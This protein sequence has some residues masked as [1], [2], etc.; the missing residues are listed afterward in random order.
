[1]KIEMNKNEN[2][3]NYATIKILFTIENNSFSFL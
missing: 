3:K 1:M 2:L